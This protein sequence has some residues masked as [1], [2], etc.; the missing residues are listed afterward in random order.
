[1]N[2]VCGRMLDRS[3]HATRHGTILGGMP[4]YRF[5]AL[6]ALIR[7]VERAAAKEPDLIGATS[8]IIKFAIDSDADPYLLVGALVEAVAVTIAQK[9]PAER[10]RKVAAD[11]LRMMLARLKANRVL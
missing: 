3:S 5:P 1:M 6:D 9:V 10:Q 2:T 7:D 8:A 4:G 11:T